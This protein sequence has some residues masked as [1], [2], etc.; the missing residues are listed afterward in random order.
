MVSDVFFSGE[1]EE[2][3][4]PAACWESAWSELQEGNSRTWAATVCLVHSQY[5]LI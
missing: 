4:S 1:Q 2:T 5:F 3:R